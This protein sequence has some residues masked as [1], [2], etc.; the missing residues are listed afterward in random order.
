MII[1]RTV[2]IECSSLIDLDLEFHSVGISMVNFYKWDHRRYT[3]PSTD[4]DDV[5]SCA[6]MLSAWALNCAL[7]DWG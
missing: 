3:L 2:G 4:V 1:Y 5:A 6:D 7:E